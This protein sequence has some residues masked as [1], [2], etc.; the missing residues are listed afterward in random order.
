ML[1]VLDNVC[2]MTFQ[3]LMCIGHALDA[4]NKMQRFVA[5]FAKKNLQ[6]REKQMQK[7][8]PVQV[9]LL[10][11]LNQI[12]K[13]TGFSASLFPNVSVSVI[14]TITQAGVFKPKP[15]QQCFQMSPYQG[16]EITGEEQIDSHIL[17]GLT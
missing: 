9:Q 3:L 10:L 15:G 8:R 5:L 11:M 1:K 6:R 7:T 16:P 14:Q 4:V 2:H 13:K 17:L 12:R